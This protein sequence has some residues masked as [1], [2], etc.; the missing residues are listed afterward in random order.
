M[1]ASK[2]VTKKE[3]LN[4]IVYVAKKFLILGMALESVSK[5]TNQQVKESIIDSKLK[6]R[7]DIQDVLKLGDDKFLMSLFN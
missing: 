2:T 6:T 3:L 7:Q 4:E 5:Q 1:K